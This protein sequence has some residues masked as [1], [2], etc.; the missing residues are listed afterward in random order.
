MPVNSIVVRFFM[1]KATFTIVV[2]SV[3]SASVGGQNINVPERLCPTVSVSCP[4]DAKV[5]SDLEVA[6]NVLP[7]VKYH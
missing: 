5:N 6:A 1:L 2:F 3:M 7:G 4:E